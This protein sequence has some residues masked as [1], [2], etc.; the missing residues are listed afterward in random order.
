MKTTLGQLVATLYSAYDRKLHD[1]ELAAVATQVR[2]FEM[3]EARIQA[4][5][6][7]AAKHAA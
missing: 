7:E 4:R 6:D 5:R 1:R 3:L 2:M